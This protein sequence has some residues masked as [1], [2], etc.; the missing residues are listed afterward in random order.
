M[1]LVSRSLGE[2]AVMVRLMRSTSAGWLVR[3]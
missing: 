1:P 3:W 2:T